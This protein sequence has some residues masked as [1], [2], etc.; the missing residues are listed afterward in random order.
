MSPDVV[1]ANDDGEHREQRRNERRG[2]RKGVDVL[3]GGEV[4]NDGRSAPGAK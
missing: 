1:H 3:W 4:R 2:L